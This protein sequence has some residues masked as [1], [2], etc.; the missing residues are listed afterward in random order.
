MPWGLAPGSL[1]KYVLF[2]LVSFCFCRGPFVTINNKQYYDA[3]KAFLQPLQ[4][5]DQVTLQDPH[6]LQWVVPRKILEVR[7]DNRWLG[8]RKQVQANKNVLPSTIKTKNQGK[9]QKAKEEK[10]QQ[11]VQK[12]ISYELVLKIPKKRKIIFAILNQ[13]I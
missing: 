6:T 12:S 1:G 3:H 10:R 8:W 7:P 9:R 5:G 13:S 4:V 11:K 2:C